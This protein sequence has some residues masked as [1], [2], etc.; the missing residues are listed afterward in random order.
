M[1]AAML[2]DLV[3]AGKPPNHKPLRLR[4]LALHLRP[5]RTTSPIP[6][7][8]PAASW[9]HSL[10]QY[11]RRTATFSEIEPEEPLRVAVP[12]GAQLG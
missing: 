2:A 7:M 8:P 11:Y 6:P 5:K 10:L 9:G 3:L 4:G 1:S 12:T